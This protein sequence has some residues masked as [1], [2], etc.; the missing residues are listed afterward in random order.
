MKTLNTDTEVI[1]STT[2]SERGFL[3]KTILR[4]NLT[5]MKW[6]DDLQYLFRFTELI[7]VQ[8]FQ[9]SGCKMASSFYFIPP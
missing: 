1:Y 7:K 4:L 8:N 2:P 6:F 3:V 9:L 5:G